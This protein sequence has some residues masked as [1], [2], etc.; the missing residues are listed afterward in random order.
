MKRAPF[1]RELRIGKRA[2]QWTGQFL[3]GIEVW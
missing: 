3:Q 2:R 1:K